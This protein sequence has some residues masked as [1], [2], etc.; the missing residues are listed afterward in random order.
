MAGVRLAAAVSGSNK[1]RCRARGPPQ[2]KPW[3][4]AGSE[5]FASK[6]MFSSVFY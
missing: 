5:I 2:M 3:P 6:K 1:D 4:E